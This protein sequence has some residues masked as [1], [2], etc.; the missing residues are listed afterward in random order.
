M[1]DWHDFLTAYGA[2][3]QDDTL[4]GFETASHAALPRLI[5]MV[6]HQ[7]LQAAGADAVKFLQG[8]CT[9]DIKKLEQEKLLLGAHCNRQGRM[10]SSFTLANLSGGIGLRLRRN[11]GESTLASLKRYI[12][13]SKAELNQADYL[14]FAILGADP[15]NVP[16]TPMPAAGHFAQGEDQVILHHRSGLIELWIH[17][18]KAAALWQSLSEHCQLAAPAELDLHL[19][20]HGIAEV[21]A[22]TQE[23]YIPQH[24]NYQAI[25]AVDFKKGCYTGQEIVA[26]M[27]YRGQLKKHCYRL[28][29]DNPLLQVP[30]GAELH[31]AAAPTKS[32]AQ[33]VASAQGEMLVVCAADIALSKTPLFIAQDPTN[34]QWAE[35]PYAIP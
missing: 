34:F 8:Q 13:F 14:G 2:R 24:L 18:D 10:I 31:S 20:Q 35:L 25:E 4:L 9:C 27:Q 21:Q 5:P 12:V 23:A 6:E 26:R 28:V 29:S 19:V 7:L 11:L 15:A 16:L 17:A 32:A 22:A 33:V 1:I 30:V 3:W